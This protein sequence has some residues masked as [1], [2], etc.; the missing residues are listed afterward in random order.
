MA[1]K[2]KHI[3]L[4][5]KGHLP[6]TV[7]GT[8]IG[9]I[10]ILVFRNASEKTTDSL[11]A[12][13]HPAH[14]LLSAIVT[15]SIFKIHAKGKN[16]LIILLIGYFGSIGVAKLSDIVVPYVG[17]N[18]LGLDSA[19]LKHS[20]S[21]EQDAEHGDEHADDAQMNHD[22]AE[23]HDEHKS[24]SQFLFGDFLIVTPAA[25]LGI[26]IAFYMPHTKFP[27]FGHVLISTWA[28]SAFLLSR[29]GGQMSIASAMEIFMVL[30][31]AVWVP[32]CLSD[33]IFPLLF[34]KGDI[35]IHGSCCNHKLHSHPHTHDDEQ[36]TQ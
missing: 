10:F 8:L 6:F 7:L 33:I 16:F 26:L 32:C 20:H 31:L 35:E 30:F 14:V 19:M 1:G 4:E 23:G 13:F 24:L 3:L 2:T 12:V 36:D 27:H 17:A 9:L 29:I 11:F 21:N 5:L 34:V 22:E 15:A 28:S 25:I 18:L